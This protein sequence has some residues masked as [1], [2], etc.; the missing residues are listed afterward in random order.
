M[1][2]ASSAVHCLRD[3]TRGG[4]ATRLNAI[5]RRSQMGI[6]LDEKRI[7]IREDVKGACEILGV[8]PLYLANEGKLITIVGRKDA[9]N[10]LE[11]MHRHRHGHDAQIIGE[12]VAHHQTL[13]VMRTGIGG[14]RIVE[15]MLGEQLPR[16]C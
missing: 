6:V 1:L 2:E 14:T 3:P 15:L 7:P 16:I 4:M 11:R 5:A 13:V 12:V 8:D 10:V 9:E